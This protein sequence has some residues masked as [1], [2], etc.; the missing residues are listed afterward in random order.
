MITSYSSF[1][2]LL[3]IGGFLL[4]G[5]TQASGQDKINLSAGFG[6]PELL[7]VGVRYQL[8]Q[9]QVGISIGAFK[10]DIAVTGDFYQHIAGSSK[11][12]NRRP[13]YTRVGMTYLWND[14]NNFLDQYLILA[15]RVGR[16]FNIS[17]NFG[18]QVG[19][20]AFFEV[21]H[22]ETKKVSYNYGRGTDFDIF[23]PAFGLT[24]F[25]RL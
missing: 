19:L 16:D 5:N 1:R 9:S 3:L 21:L 2:N 24:I 18:F 13:L 12:S 10:E 23:I 25:Y 17:K 20:G 8:N 14:G 6:L 11:F 15:L 4:L 22:H 7:N